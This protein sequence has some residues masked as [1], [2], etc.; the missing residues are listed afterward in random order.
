MAHVLA[1]HDGL[2]TE[3]VM[4]QRGWFVKSTGDGI[5]AAF[6]RSAWAVNAA[7]DA[8]LALSREEFGQLGKLEVRTVIAT[9]EADERDGDYFGPVL[10]DAARMLEACEGGQVLVSAVTRA[11]VGD[12]LPAGTRWRQVVDPELHSSQPLYELIQV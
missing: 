4:A 9:G 6:Q 10:N 11:V 1:R 8:Q 7:H 5:L 3:H 2:L 12:S